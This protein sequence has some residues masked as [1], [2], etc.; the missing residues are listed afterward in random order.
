MLSALTLITANILR[1]EIY[2]MSLA[3]GA[4]I[5]PE[6]SAV[7][8]VTL[9]FGRACDSVLVFPRDLPDFWIFVWRASPL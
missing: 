6:E 5:E 1:H 3:L 4:V 9:L 2:A 7:Q 8:V